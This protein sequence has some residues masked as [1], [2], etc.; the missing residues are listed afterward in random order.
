MIF[1]LLNMSGIAEGFFS[2]FSARNQEISDKTD[3]SE[4]EDRGCAARGSV[5]IVWPSWMESSAIRGGSSKSAMLRPAFQGV[6]QAIIIAKDIE[7]T[8]RQ[9]SMRHQEP[10]LIFPKTLLLHLS[11]RSLCLDVYGKVKFARVPR[12]AR[13]REQRPCQDSRS[14]STI[15]CVLEGECSRE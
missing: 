11:P 7:N 10:L 12:V 6:G 3:G 1:C 2:L 8:Y 14:A 5:Y 9:D 4:D 15:G 13:R